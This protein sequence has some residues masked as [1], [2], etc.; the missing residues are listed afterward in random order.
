MR[1]KTVPS[2]TV[3]G[4]II[5]MKISENYITELYDRHNRQENLEVGTK[6]EEA[7]DEKGPYIFL[8]EVEKL[9]RR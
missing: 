5:V 7:A 3:S 8:S 9:S 2:S 6:K 1:F 4:N